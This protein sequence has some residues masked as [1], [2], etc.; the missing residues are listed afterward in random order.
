MSWSMQRLFISRSRR[1]HSPHWTQSSSIAANC[2]RVIIS[3]GAS[4]S[5]RDNQG[6][7]RMKVYPN[8][9]SKNKIMRVA[10][11]HHLHR[12]RRMQLHPAGGGYSL[13]NKP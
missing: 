5:W 11:L 2:A 7:L 4:P 3:E 1:T 13:T 12:I 9:V 8:M 10:L 6:A